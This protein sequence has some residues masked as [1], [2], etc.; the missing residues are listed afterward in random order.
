[1]G[2]VEIHLVARSLQS[3]AISIELQIV[4]RSVQCCA[5]K[6]AAHRKMMRMS[7]LD[8]I[9]SSTFSIGTDE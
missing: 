5:K 1:M 4:F 6:K 3:L 8:S 2:N 7:K 9:S